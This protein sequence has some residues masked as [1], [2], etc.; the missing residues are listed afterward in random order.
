MALRRERGA[1][2]SE[3]ATAHIQGAPSNIYLGMMGQGVQPAAIG[4]H[5]ELEAGLDASYL[6]QPRDFRKAPRASLSEASVAQAAI[7]VRCRTNSSCVAPISPHRRA[8]LL[9]PQRDGGKACG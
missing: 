9:V 5:R 7:A 8:R 4:P 6:S 3:G 2:A 1:Q